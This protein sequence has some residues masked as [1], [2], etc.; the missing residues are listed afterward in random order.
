V[1]VASAFR[2]KSAPSADDDS[3]VNRGLGSAGRG[4]AEPNARTILHARRDAEADVVAR[5]P[6]PHPAA[7]NAPVI[8]H[9]ATPSALEADASDGQV[10]GD[11]RT[12]NGFL[13]CDD[14]FRPTSRKW[15]V[16]EEGVT[17][18]IQNGFDGRK[19]DRDL[20]GQA[21][22]HH[23]GQFLI[24]DIRMVALCELPVRPLDFVGARICRY[25]EHVVVVAHEPATDVTS[26]GPVAAR[27]IDTNRLKARC[28]KE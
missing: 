27:E 12:P 4:D 2:R 8:P 7:R 11:G 13:W 9:L 5:R 26:F 1:F 25:A 24:S 19:I 14:D 15:R 17:H 10:K 23:R 16:P 20:V 28:L 18:T 6:M 3:G 21:V 22:H